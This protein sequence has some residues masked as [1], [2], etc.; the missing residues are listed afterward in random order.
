MY[1][2]FKKDAKNIYLGVQV[3]VEVSGDCR[4]VLGSLWDHMEGKVLCDC[5]LVS[6][7]IR[8]LSAS[9]GAART[10]TAKDQMASLE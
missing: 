2:T 1:I 5:V 10:V 8:T 6:I 3:I 7:S 4:C 9:C